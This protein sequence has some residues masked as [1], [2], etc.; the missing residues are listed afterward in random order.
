MPGGSFNDRPTQHQWNQ[1]LDANAWHCV[2]LACQL[3]QV[4]AERIDRLRDK[5]TQETA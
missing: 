4:K 2:T 5:T 3:R 1:R